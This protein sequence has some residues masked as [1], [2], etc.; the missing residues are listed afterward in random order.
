MDA[1]LERSAIRPE[2]SPDERILIG[3]EAPVFLCPNIVNELPQVRTR[4]DDDSLLELARSMVKGDL[5]EENEHNIFSL[6]ELKAKLILINP[7]VVGR[8]STLERA[9]EYLDAH[10]DHYGL[11]IPRAA[12]SLA[13]AD[14]GY[15]Y[16]RIAGHRRRRAI[17]L[18]QARFGI[19]DEQLGIASTPHTD[20]TFEEALG[21][22]LRENIYEAP[23][24]HEEA[25][26]IERYYNYLA[27][28]EGR[29]PTIKALAGHLGMSPSKVGTALAFASLPHEVQDL[30]PGS[31]P[32]TTVSQ[33]KPLYELYLRQH[34]IRRQNGN[35]AVEARDDFAREH[36]LI[37]ANRLIN[38]R[39]NRTGT[40]AT[41]II[42]AHANEL[43]GQMS[44]QTGELFLMEDASVAKRRTRSDRILGETAISTIE[45]FMRHGRLTDEERARLASVLGI[46]VESLRPEPTIPDLFSE[47]SA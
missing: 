37:I 4:Y 42:Q 32:Y 14:D 26:S 13:Q 38:N 44:Y 45:Y 30:T 36:I 41:A 34:D 2:Y 15:Y 19:A 7:Q 29:Q 10:A 46:A 35:P 24:A 23:P 9:Q 6:D 43:L 25:R 3:P 28:K 47:T 12:E 5:P 40:K 8:F 16:L 1:G 18:L 21:L 20:I 17:G 33:L 27:H 31:L 39:L 22:Q 11:D